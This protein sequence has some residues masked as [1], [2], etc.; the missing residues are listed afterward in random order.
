MRRQ[1]RVG[2]LQ[3]ILERTNQAILPFTR[4]CIQPNANVS[5]IIEEDTPM[6][7]VKRVFWGLVLLGALTF[8]VGLYFGWFS[9]SSHHDVEN[10]R[11]L[12]I[13]EINRGKITG[14]TNS[15][16]QKASEELGLPVGTK[17]ATGTLVKVDEADRFTL[18][19]GDRNE[20]TFHVRSTSKF[21]LKD[22]Q[23]G[24]KMSVSY[25]VE[26]QE[27]VA[28]MVTVEWNL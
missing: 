23:P 25:K 21:R 28:Q 27:N 17:T 18:K 22:L 13:L 14:D 8:G 12:L 20:I 2:A 19:T 1:V 10:N 6:R 9:F 7:R 24:D 4:W 15:A 11:T 5:I 26:D 16:R 3:M